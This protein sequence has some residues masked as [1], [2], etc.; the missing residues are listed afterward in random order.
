MKPYVLTYNDAKSLVICGDIHGDFVPMV[1]EA[2]VRYGMRDTLVIVAGDCGFGFEKPSAYDLVFRRIEKRLT[3]SNCWIAM[4]RGNHDDPT[5]FELNESGHTPI[6]HKR[7]RTIPDYTVVQACG[8]AVLCVGGAISVDRQIRLREMARHS[9][10]VYYWPNEAVKYDAEKLDTI[11]DAGLKIDVVV[12]HTAPSFC[13]YRSKQ[14]L[15]TW[16]QEDSTLIDECEAERTAMDHILAHLKRDEHPLER[17]YYGHFHNSWHS[18]ID[19]VWYKML[20]IME[21]LEIPRS[22]GR[23]IN[24]VKIDGWS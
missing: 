19:G 24:K 9:G 12:S 10:K 13:E 18:E 1:Y 5:Y 22:R 15:A 20:D 16:A 23:G 21:M 7:W 4:V 2:C 8:R 17:W 6:E 3:E 11:R 14:G